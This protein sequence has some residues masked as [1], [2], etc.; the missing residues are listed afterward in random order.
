MS[1]V[2][3]RV[4]N[5]R[6]S[7]PFDGRPQSDLSKVYATLGVSL[8][9]DAWMFGLN[10][11]KAFLPLKFVGKSKEKS[12]P[13][14]PYMAPRTSK[15]LFILADPEA[16]IYYNT[17]KVRGDDIAV[18]LS[19]NVTDEYLLHLRKA[20]V[21]YLFGGPDG[22][23]LKKAMETLGDVF[24]I[25]SISLQGGAIIDGAMLADGLLDELS[26]VM[27]PGI[28]GL[29]GVPS[30]FQYVGG[31]TDCPARGQSLELISVERCDFGVVHLCYK[32][33]RKP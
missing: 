22:I 30:I 33:H 13:R 11:A 27:Y 16:G 5:S 31:Q 12:M 14:E 1:S 8:G 32:F 4:D 17:A 25:K 2:D 23:D 24:G 9:T 19:E 28:D 3:G 21:S 7:K 6:W 29:A 15:R 20:G 10:T 18:I 26:L